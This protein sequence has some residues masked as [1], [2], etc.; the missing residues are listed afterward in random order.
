M[1]MTYTDAKGNHVGYAMSHNGG[2]T[3]MPVVP[4]SEPAGNVSS[5]G[6]NAPRLVTVPTMTYA[7]WEQRSHK[8]NNELVVARSLDY[9]HSF[10]RPVVVTGDE[11]AAYHGFASL[12][13][14]PSGDVYAVWLD[15]RE[16]VRD[17]DTFALYLAKSSDQGATFG[18][19]RRVAVSACPCC[20]PAIAFGPKGEVLLAWRKVFDGHVR[21]LVVSTSADAGETFA[22]EVRVADDGWR[23]DGCPDSGPALTVNAGRVYVAWLTE[24]REQKSRIQLSWSDDQGKSFHAPVRA[25]GEVLDANHPALKT[26]EDGKVV[27]AFQGRA[28]NS[29]KGWGQVGVFLSQV[30]GDDISPPE[31]V[32][33]DGSSAS[34]PALGLGTAG[35]VFIAWTSSGD[36]GSNVNLLRTRTE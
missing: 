33:S 12:G 25:S 28:P 19:P 32:P 2:D 6:E 8:G 35:R 22:P 30:R 14:S 24:G 26:S 36:Q 31:A 18:K 23:L 15:G 7:L 10:Q 4:V 13:V 20:R 34:Y 9:G 5:H 21:D 17:S 3:F 29:Q 1:V 27:L 16:A 11:S